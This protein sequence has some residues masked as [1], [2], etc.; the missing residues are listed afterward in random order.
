MHIHHSQ[1]T[2]CCML[3]NFQLL[4]SYPAISDSSYS[5]L[6]KRN[7]NCGLLS[8]ACG[9][10]AFY[11]LTQQTEEYSYFT[12]HNAKQISNVT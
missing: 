4:G 10:L 11:T 5:F 2:L 3:I 12:G 7:I 6:C 9:L 1:A 8:R